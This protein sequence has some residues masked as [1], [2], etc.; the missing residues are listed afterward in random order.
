MTL[1][2]AV[3]L[4]SFPGER[5]VTG[6]VTLGPGRPS[7]SWVVTSLPPAGARTVD[8]AGEPASCKG[9]PKQGSFGEE[10]IVTRAKV[11]VG[12]DVAKDR[13]DVAQRPG[14][15]IWWVTNDDGGIADL[16]A[17]LKVIRPTLVVLE[18]TGGI[19][20]PLVGT[21]AAA[22]LPVVVVNPRQTREFARATGRLAKTDAIDAQVLAQFAEA[23]RPALRPLA[24]AA[25]QQLS[26]LVARRRQVIEMLTAEKNR[27]R[28]AAPAVRGHVKEHILWLERSLSEL[29]SELGQAIQSSDVW[30]A[31]DDLLQSAPGVGPVLSITLLAHLPELGSLSRKE[32]AALV[33]VAPLN[34]DSGTL[35]GR[36]T[37]W[38]GRPQVR[39]VL[40]M[41]A[42]VATRRNPII[43]A[44]YQR[45]L[46]AGKPKKVALTA[47]MRKLLTILNAMLRYQSPWQICSTS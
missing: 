26:S 37:V 44:F 34:R 15:E 31:R 36:R 46:A 13:L 23:V 35:R 38:G 12:I 4:V 16:V 42:L 7:L 11:Y 25:T 40:Y 41:G 6:R 19:E 30:R 22:G 32:I 21:L 24:N 20:L 17:R 5:D 8:G 14:T 28:T 2:H 39:A 27:L 33:G 45:L 10:E 29:D 1:G 18:A 47:C 9:G 3:T 43:Q